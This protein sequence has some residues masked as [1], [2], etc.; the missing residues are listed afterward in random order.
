MFKNEKIDVDNYTKHDANVSMKLFK[1]GILAE[2]DFDNSSF[3]S[4][5]NLRTLLAQKL[6]QLSTVTYYP[7]EK[8]S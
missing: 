5:P 1:K 8:I 6:R 2:F 3:G 7:F 4:E